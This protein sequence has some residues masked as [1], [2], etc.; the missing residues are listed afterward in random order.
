MSE[1]LDRLEALAET[2]L[3]AIKQQKEQQDRDRENWRTQQDRDREDWRTAITDVALMIGALGEKMGEMQAEVR[4]LQTENQRI[5][6]YLFNQQ[7][8]AN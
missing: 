8:N 3:L 6:D 5:L 7:N 2:I 1:R 4:G